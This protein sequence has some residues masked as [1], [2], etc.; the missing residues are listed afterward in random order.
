MKPSVLSGDDRREKMLALLKECE[1]PLSGGKLGSVF[2]VSRQV[3]VQDI[4]LLRSKGHPILSTSCGYVYK[5]D[6]I[7]SQKS[8]IIKVCH[9]DSQVEDELN[10][11]IDLGGIVRNVMVNHRTYGKVSA[12]LDI[13]SRRD[14]KH[15]TEDIQTS[16]SSLLSNT[17]SG[18]HFHTIEAESDDILDEIEQALK[19]KGYL[20]DFLDYEKANF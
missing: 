1:K 5:N 4:A 11:I 14:I 18:Y 20:A 12:P 6:T 10:T 19:E 8:R 9:T 16:K 17:T 2:S 15:F 3:I 13:K 7:G